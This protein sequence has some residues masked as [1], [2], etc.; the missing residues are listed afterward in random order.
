MG[1]DKLTKVGLKVTIQRIAILDCLENSNEHPNAEMVFNKIHQKY[2]SITVSTVYNTLEKFVEKKIIKKVFTLDGK[3]RYDAKTEKH[4]HLYDI[5][6]GEI[7]D[8]YDKNLNKTIEKFLKKF[9][10]KKYLIED[11]QIDFT[12]KI[13]KQ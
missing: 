7:I 10:N 8:I 3:A 4:H 9:N 2:P 5:D 1:Y 11:Y 12:G 6:T 13:K